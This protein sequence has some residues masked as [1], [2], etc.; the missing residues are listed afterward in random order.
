MRIYKNIVILFLALFFSSCTTSKENTASQDNRIQVILDSIQTE[1]YNENIVSSDK[2]PVVNIDENE[3]SDFD[4]NEI[5][6]KV[7]KEETLREAVKNSVDRNNTTGLPI[8]QEANRQIKK[9]ERKKILIKPLTDLRTEPHNLTDKEISDFIENVK[10]NNEI[11]EGK[12]YSSKEMNTLIENYKNILKTSQACCVSNMTENFKIHNLTQDQIFDILRE[13]AQDLQIQDKCLIISENDI[14]N[15][16]DGGY[17]S[18]MVVKARNICICN[19]KEFLRKNVNNFYRIYNKD[20]EF[21][22]TPLFYKYKD[23]YG[24]VVIDD[25]NQSIINMAL[26]LESCP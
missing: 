10:N 13:D 22:K 7:G 26:T 20:E 19:N 23:R 21:Y 17:V 16:F 12:T 4:N 8:Y 2:Q 25:V 9:I 14:F 24:R 15:S 11:D 3:I 6:V 1:N 18:D 5:E